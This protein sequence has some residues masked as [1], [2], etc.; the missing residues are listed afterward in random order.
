MLE[1]LHS[2]MIAVIQ[3][4]GLNQSELNGAAKN[5]TAFIGWITRGLYCSTEPLPNVEPR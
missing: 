1:W 3:C 2:K 5:V 4:D